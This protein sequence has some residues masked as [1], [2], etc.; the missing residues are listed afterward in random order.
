MPKNDRNG[1][2]LLLAARLLTADKEFRPGAVL[3]QEGRIVDAGASID[4]RGGRAVDLPGLT[5][6]P[7]FIDLHVHGG[8][9]YSLAGDK[10]NDIR[11]YSR[12]APQHGVTA[13]LAG[14]V[15]G[16]PAGAAPAISAAL[17]G[18]PGEGA[19]MLGLN[20]EG[21]FVNPARRGALPVTWPAEPGERLLSDLLAASAGRLRLITIAPELPGALA[22]IRDAVAAGVR[23]SAGHTDAG[24]AQALAGF[25]AGATHVTHVLNGMRPFHHREPGVVGAA[26]DSPGVT[27]EV[28]ADGVHLHPA[29]V[30]MLLRSFGPERVALITDAVAPAGLGSGAFRLGGQEARLDGGR[31]TLPDGTIAGSAAT[32]DTVVANLVR[33]GAASLAEAVRM[34]STVPAMVAGVS[35]RKG[36][37]APGYDAD[38]VALG[39]DLRVEATWTRGRPA[40]GAPGAQS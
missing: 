18:E 25:E 22:L 17:A 24:Y 14:I 30:R 9:G 36:R 19:E 35:G 4:A 39:D 38:I 26:L 28:I 40:Y 34:A 20:L 3:L 10:P 7:G 2:L 6:V 29:T 16:R 1:P 21:P 8:G 15:A 31:V 37:I 5:L 23:V 13:F 11:S 12:W 27:I 33:W 32:M